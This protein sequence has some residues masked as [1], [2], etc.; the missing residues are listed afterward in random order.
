MYKA[1]K[2]GPLKIGSIEIDAAVLD[3]PG[4]P[5][6]VLSTRGVTRA[7][8][9][10]RTGTVVG[11]P[12]LPPFLASNAIKPFISDDLMA[13]LNS[14][15]E[16]APRH[17]GRTAFGYDGALLAEIC[18]VVITAKDAGTLRANQVKYAAIA[19]SLLQGVAVIGI[20]SL[21]DEATGYQ[22]IRDRVALQAILDQFLR[23]EWA[24]WAKRFPDEFYEL[25]FGL[26][27][28]QYRPLNVKRPG[29][30]GHWTNDLVYDR[31]AP[32][33][34]TELR[35]R[36][37]PTESGK[38]RRKH[39]QWLTEDVGHPALREHLSNVITLMKAAPNWATFY[40]LLQRAKPKLGDMPELPFPERDTP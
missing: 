35:K 27:G 12:K 39:H 18:K 38:R 20:Y 9:G 11:A 33:V 28:W 29:V 10:K 23:K 15:V 30:I 2:D 16:Y 19:Q 13:R 40:R 24:K 5:M 8:G 37:P 21:I 14:P 3:N 6:R 31:L 34:L 22:D 32:G 36:N 4:T 7:L 1:I 25:L 17:G 26:R